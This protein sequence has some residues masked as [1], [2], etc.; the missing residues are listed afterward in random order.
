MMGLGFAE[1]VIIAIVGFMILAVVGG[2]LAAVL[3]A[4]S[5]SGRESK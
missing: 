5:S 4:G 3:I 2:I 1:I